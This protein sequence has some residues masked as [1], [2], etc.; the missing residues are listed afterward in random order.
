MNARNAIV[1]IFIAAAVL[2]TAMALPIFGVQHVT[3][4][5][6]KDDATR[7]LRGPIASI[8]L[9]A[10]GQPEW[11][12]SG[13]WV[14][15][16]FSSNPQNPNVQLIAR[17]E[18]VKPDGTSAHQHGV[19]D[20]KVA[21]VTQEGNSTNVFKGPAP[22]TMKNGPV[23]GVPVT[24]KVFH[25][26]VIGIWIGPD[27]VESHFGTGP[28]YGTLSTASSKEATA[29]T[30]NATTATATPM[31]NG[32]SGSSAIAPSQNATTTNATATTST[33]TS[34]IKMTAQ[35]VNENYRWSTS[36]G[37]NPTIKMTANADNTVQIANPTDAKHELVI[38]SNG[39]EVAS[40]GDIAAN[41]SGQLSFKPTAAGTYE[42]HCE[43]H[44]TT[45]KGT[46]EV[47]A[48]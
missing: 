38:E 8:Q 36:D 9:G 44:P 48:H 18:M 10:N 24:V 11:I 39:K 23:T 46:I 28:I 4:A 40:S 15:R 6:D 42:Y 20:F 45:M 35:E 27:K 13:I 26:A 33:T 5:S 21:N 37:V 1:P 2:G 16:I 43:Y 32:T 19:S 30:A 17:F 34:S 3:A 22:V 7:T 47:S 25:N 41:G 12:Q 31:S 29:T 14:M